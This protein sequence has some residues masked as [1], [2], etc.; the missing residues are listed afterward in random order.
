MKKITRV[1]GI[2]LAMPLTMN[3]AMRWR[4]SRP[5]QGKASD[6]SAGNRAARAQVLRGTG[7][8]LKAHT[9]RDRLTNKTTVV[10]ARPACVASTLASNTP[11]RP[12]PSRQATRRERCTAEPPRRLPQ[13]WCTTL[14]RLKAVKVPVRATAHHSS[15]AC[16][17]CTAGKNRAAKPAPKAK[18]AQAAA[19]KARGGDHRASTQR[20]NTGSITA[21]NKRVPNKTRP[22][23][24]KGTPNWA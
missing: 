12:R 4:N 23:S 8:L 10:A 20:P 9:P 13:A 7:A 16:V 24:A 11:T 14:A 22:S 18:A 15:K 2:A 21:S 19:F 3:K 5:R 17:P 1:A 6:W